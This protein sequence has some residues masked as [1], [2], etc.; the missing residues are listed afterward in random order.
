MSTTA[1]AP[2][3]RLF[4]FDCLTVASDQ[5]LAQAERRARAQAERQAVDVPSAQARQFLEG[6]VGGTH[7]GAG[8]DLVVGRR[9]FAMQEAEHGAER[10][11]ANAP[12]AHAGRAQPVFVEIEPAW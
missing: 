6:P 8:G 5:A 1:V 2:V 7:A 9:L 10:R 12:V 11:Q 4:T 3:M